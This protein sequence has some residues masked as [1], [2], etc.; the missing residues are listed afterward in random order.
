MRKRPPSRPSKLHRLRQAR[1]IFLLTHL[2]AVRS[3]DRASKR[4]SSLLETT[5]DRRTGDSRS[6]RVEPREK[7]ALLV[8][9]D[10]LE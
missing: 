3:L 1:P 4:G 10:V 2:R 5:V 7:A 8:H 9:P 6:A